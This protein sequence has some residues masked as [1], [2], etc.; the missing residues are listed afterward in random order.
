MNG[1]A[2]EGNMDKKNNLMQTA[3]V[4]NRKVSGRPGQPPGPPQ[5]GQPQTPAQ[6]MNKPHQQPQVSQLSSQQNAALQQVPAI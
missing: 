5:Q 2:E 3:I 4:N 1:V 6:L